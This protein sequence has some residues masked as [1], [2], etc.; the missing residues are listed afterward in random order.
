M[1]IRSYPDKDWTRIHNM[2]LRDK[3]LS[4]K[5]K[6][7]MAYL[8]TL[9]NDWDVSFSELLTHH[10][11]RERSTRGAMQ[12]L[13]ENGYV[14]VVMRHEDGHIVGN[15]Y[16]I[17]EDKIQHGDFVNG[18]NVNGQNVNGQ[19]EAL[20]STNKIL[21]TNIYKERKYIKERNDKLLANYK[22][23]I[24]VLNNMT[25]RAFKTDNVSSLSLIRARVKDGS[26]IEE[27][28]NVV[29]FICKKRMGTDFEMFLRPDTIFN[30]TKYESYLQEF[31]HLT[32]NGKYA[33]LLEDKN[34]S[35]LRDLD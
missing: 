4:L 6:G 27:I 7:L 9:P 21:S 20:L 18:Q 2:V 1:I 22:K 30:R 14:K 19:K 32:N 28:C 31:L 3:K 26:P 29:E 11:D 35:V 5:A 25:G 17:F 34:K 23:P 16:Y 8:L 15:N 24:E 13:V 33:I 12:E 10:T